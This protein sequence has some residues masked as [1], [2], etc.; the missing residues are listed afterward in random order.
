MTSSQ[1]NKISQE[2]VVIRSATV[3]DAEALEALADL[4][5]AR[6][7]SGSVLIA[8]VGGQAVAAVALETGQAIANPFMAT[9]QL[10]ELLGLRAR[11]VDS[12]SGPAAHGRLAQWRSRLAPAGRRGHGRPLTAV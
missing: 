5:S 8:E 2:A 7:P 10:V 11:Q 12:A 6:P 4:D 9:A 3:S 1:R